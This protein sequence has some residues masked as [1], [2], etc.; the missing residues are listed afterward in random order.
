V[1]VEESVDW[2]AHGNGIEASQL[3]FLYSYK[4]CHAL[5]RCAA[6]LGRECCP[7]WLGSGSGSDGCFDILT[8]G[9]GD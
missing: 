8:G 1:A 6:F 2:A 5:E 4:L 7:G 3:V 9:F